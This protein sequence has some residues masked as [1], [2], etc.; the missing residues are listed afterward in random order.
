MC[1]IPVLA[2]TIHSE[3]FGLFA[4][5]WI[6]FCFSVAHTT[7]PGVAKD[8][9]MLFVGDSGCH[10]GSAYNKGSRQLPLKPNVAFSLLCLNVN[11]QI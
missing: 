6:L 11:K 8:T 9:S 10:T 7:A 4:S 2:A 1:I 5:I 3:I